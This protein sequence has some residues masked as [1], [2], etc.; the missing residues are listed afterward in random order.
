MPADQEGMLANDAIDSALDGREP[1]ESDAARVEREAAELRGR[2]QAQQ[3]VIARQQRQMEELTNSSRMLG[4]QLSELLDHSRTARDNGFAFARQDIE[5]QRRAA[6]QSSDLQ[7]YDAL[8][9][10]LMALDERRPQPR[11]QQTTEPASDR[12]KTAPNPPA[13][14][15]Q[16]DP[17]VTAWFNDNPWYNTDWELR[18]Y[19]DGAYNNLLATSAGKSTQ[20][21]LA[22]VADKTRKRFP[23]K[24]PTA[25]RDHPSPVSRPGPQGGKPSKPKTKTVADLPDDAKQALARIKRRDPAFTDDDYLKSYQ[26]DK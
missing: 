16:A 24:F 22:E 20:Q 4:D 2:V 10:Q 13:Q 9:R 23:D 26:W 21:M 18:S 25:A 3:D 6:V 19:A 7:T 12:S 17:S 1:G 14:Q 11:S 8:T 15:T 5:A